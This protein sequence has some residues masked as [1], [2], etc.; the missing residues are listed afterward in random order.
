MSHNTG[1]RI[2]FSSRA[3]IKARENRLPFL[4][5]LVAAGSL[6]YAQSAFADPSAGQLSNPPLP[7]INA[8]DTPMSPAE[9][10]E[11]IAQAKPA[12]SLDEPYRIF[13]AVWRG[14]EDACQGF[15]DY[16]RNNRIPVDITIRDAGR[17]RSLLPVFLKEIEATQPDLVVTWGTTVSVGMLG[18]SDEE[19]RSQFL[20][21]S[22]PAVFMIVSQP[23]ASG[24]V[25]NLESSGRN[26]TG[27]SYLVPEETQLR[28][29]RSYLDFKK[30]AIVYNP[31]EPNTLLNVET[32]QKLQEK[33]NFTLI[34][35]PIAL[36]EDGNPMTSSIAER[37]RYVH[38]QG[39]D[40]LYQGP[41]SFLNVNRDILTGTALEL[42]LPVFAAGENPVRFSNA[43]MGVINRYYTVG[44]LTA[45][46]ARQILVDGVRPEDIPIEAPK[47]FSYMINLKAA[48]KLGLFP[49]M[50]LMKFAEIIEE[51]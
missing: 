4:T 6:L 12:G 34:E 47:R 10:S 8:T 43:L 19:D 28:A 31:K 5:A 29:A 16:F 26:I 24:I 14:C 49:P 32:L 39:A 27:T 35:A 2:S 50:N 30:L 38:D 36:D 15:Q 18:K 42:G 51:Q 45:H 48:R 7:M 13:L 46:K 11:E 22:I 33:N 40:L 44:Q 37:V 41:D 1:S 9:R 17:D 21:N 25:P 3:S 20:D 23:I